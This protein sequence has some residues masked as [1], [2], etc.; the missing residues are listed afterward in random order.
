[1]NIRKLSLASSVVFGLSFLMLACDDSSSSG[2]DMVVELS[3]SSSENANL[4]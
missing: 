1:M 3:S 4:Q 2:P